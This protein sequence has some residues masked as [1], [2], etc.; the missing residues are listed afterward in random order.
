MRPPP[1]CRPSVGASAPKGTCRWLSPFGGSTVWTAL[2]YNYH[3]AAG[4]ILF[5]QLKY[6]TGYYKWQRAVKARSVR[7][8]V[9]CAPSGE[10][11]ERVALLESNLA[12]EAKLKTKSQAVPTGKTNDRKRKWDQVDGGKASSGRPECPNM[13]SPRTSVLICVLMDGRPMCA[14]GHTRKHTDS[15]ERPV[16]G[17]YRRDCPKLQGNQSKGRGEASRPVQGRG[18]TS[19]PR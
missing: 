8:C 1:D 2:N 11:V 6:S 5:R 19:T 13:L 7:G 15:H 9:T 18:Q 3:Q 12:E 10:L 4:R 14:D 17:H 16:C